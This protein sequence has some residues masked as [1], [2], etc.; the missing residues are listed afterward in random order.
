MRQHLTRDDSVPQVLRLE[1]TFLILVFNFY[2]FPHLFVGR[3]CIVPDVSRTYHFGAKGLNMNSFFQD[4][5]FTKK[6]LNTKTG[7]SF[8]TNIMGKE[9]YDKE[10]HRLIK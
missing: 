1:A 8:N 3:E 9:A 10:I 2:S 7:I 5:Y 6:A 4:L